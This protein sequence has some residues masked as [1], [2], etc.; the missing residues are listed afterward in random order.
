MLSHLL[1]TAAL[2]P[3]PPSIGR[4]PATPKYFHCSCAAA[5]I[6]FTHCRA[7][8]PVYPYYCFAA[9]ILIFHCITA[10]IADKSDEFI[11]IVPDNTTAAT[12]DSVGNIFSCVE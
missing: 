3:P 7:A 2:P 8:T 10:A 12:T 1:N 6:I 11:G 5:I 4:R 9:A